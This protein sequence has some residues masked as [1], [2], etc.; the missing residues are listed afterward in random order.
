MVN[1]GVEIIELQIP[2]SDPQADGPFFT[3]ANQIALENG[4][5]VRECIE[6]AE[7]MTK[8]HINCNFVFMTYYNILFKYGVDSFVK[9]ASKVN[10]KGII[11]P[12][13][14]IEEAEEYIQSCSNYGVAPI[15]MYSPTTSNKRMKFIAQHAEGFIYCQARSGV[16]GSHT[17]F[18][19]EILDYIDRCRASTSLPIAMGFGVQTKKD[20]VFLQEKVDIAICCTQAVKILVNRSAKDMGWFL[21]GLRN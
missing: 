1:A 19:D 4:V 11:I 8:K 6:F 9:N 14:P 17:L 21:K 2:F 3:N 7:K 20:V 16:T 12:D 18:N 15:F 10:I 5:S 13:L